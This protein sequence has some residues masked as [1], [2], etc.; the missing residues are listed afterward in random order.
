M[1]STISARTHRL[2]VC[3]PVRYLGSQIFKIV[4][5]KSLYLHLMKIH[6][7]TLLGPWLLKKNILYL[8]CISN[9]ILILWCHKMP[10]KIHSCQVSNPCG[11]FLPEL[12]C[13]SVCSQC[14]CSLLWTE[15]HHTHQAAWTELKTCHL[16]KENKSKGIMKW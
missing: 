13:T 4:L 12:C 15:I 14:G 16:H 10:H 1:L 5:V 6:R 8:L 7:P 9:L 3:R 2:A 11:L